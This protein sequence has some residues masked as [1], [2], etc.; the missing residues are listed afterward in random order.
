MKIHINCLKIF[1]ISQVMAN[2]SSLTILHLV[3]TMNSGGIERGT[4]EISEA[5][6]KE[7]FKSIVTKGVY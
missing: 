5:I 4:I 3:P 6:I 1:Q 2:K 7:G